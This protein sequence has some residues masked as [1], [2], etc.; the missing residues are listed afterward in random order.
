MHDPM[1]KQTFSLGLGYLDDSIA[2]NRDQDCQMLRAVININE[3]IR[4][5][6][7]AH[8]RG[9]LGQLDREITYLASLGDTAEKL[10]Q[11][12]RARHEGDHQMWWKLRPAMTFKGNG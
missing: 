12:D 11:D 6:R 3:T 4:R 10:E 2:L 7:E 8:S 5:M 1:T 9:D